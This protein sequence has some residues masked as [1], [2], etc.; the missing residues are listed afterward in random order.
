MAW[1]VG[2]VS[3][4]APTSWGAPLSAGDSPATPPFDPAASRADPWCPPVRARSEADRFPPLR[5]PASCRLAPVCCIRSSRHQFR[6]DRLHAPVRRL[7]RFRATHPTHPVLRIVGPIRHKPAPSDFPGL[8]VPRAAVPPGD[9]IP[10][11]PTIFLPSPIPHRELAR[12]RVIR[13]TAPL[14]PRASSAAMRPRS[15]PRCPPFRA[16]PLPGLPWRG[17]S[18]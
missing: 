2:E 12:C 18:R 16:L 10:F 9:F 7:T 15:G 1:D 3:P 5:A 4:P 17:P 8:A 11:G 14:L 13:A 6:G